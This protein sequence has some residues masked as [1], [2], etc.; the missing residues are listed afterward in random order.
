M[1]KSQLENIKNTAKDYDMEIEEVAY[2]YK[3]TTDDFYEKLEEFINER[4][5]E[6]Y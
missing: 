3:N 4:A 5:K 6:N 1:T 2:I